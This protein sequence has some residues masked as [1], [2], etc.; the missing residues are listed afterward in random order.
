MC[1][2]GERNFGTLRPDESFDGATGFSSIWARRFKALPARAGRSSAGLME[3]RE[4]W[5]R[6][7]SSATGRFQEEDGAAAWTLT[8]RSKALRGERRATAFPGAARRDMGDG[9]HE[10][11]RT[12][13]ARR[14]RDA[15]GAR[16][17]RGCEFVQ[18]S[19]TR[20]RRWFAREWGEEFILVLRGRLNDFCLPAHAR[21]LQVQAVRWAMMPRFS[22]HLRWQGKTSEL[23]QPER[24]ERQ[25]SVTLS[26]HV[27]L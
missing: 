9:F 16:H 6:S 4:H 22:V 20:H 21:N 5:A 15:I 12:E 7:A 10:L 23:N 19:P 8:A 1:R 13:L 26:L 2:M 17:R 11:F 18:S 27:P 3:K 14:I 25:R 24:T